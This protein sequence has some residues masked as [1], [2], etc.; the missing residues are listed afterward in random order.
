M[1]HIRWI[2]ILT[3]YSWPESKCMCDCIETLANVGNCVIFRHLTDT[4]TERERHKHQSR[5]QINIITYIQ[6]V[7]AVL[8]I[9]FPIS[10]C[11]ELVSHLLFLFFYSVVVFS[12][13][14]QIL[15]FSRLQKWKYT[16][17]KSCAS[18]EVT[19]IHTIWVN[20][21]DLGKLYVNSIDSSI[22][23][24]L[25]TIFTSS[26]SH[27]FDWIAMKI[28]LF[29]VYDSPTLS[30][31]TNKRNNAKC[32]VSC[33]NLFGWW[34]EFKATMLSIANDTKNSKCLNYCVPSSCYHPTSSNVVLF[35][36]FFLFF[37]WFNHC[38]T[39]YKITHSHTW[40][41]TIIYTYFLFI[42]LLLGMIWSLRRR[43]FFGCD[44]CNCKR[45]IAGID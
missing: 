17:S 8:Y 45:K 40:L 15:S 32:Q 16:N 28:T 31:E 6:K 33:T 1:R 23:I 41:H 21:I 2:C 26:I 36:L 37:I 5:S 29:I 43:T 42:F 19:T 9:I 44:I 39:L 35:S 22:F 18:N 4:D 12:I 27:T 20:S 14:V 38:S 11:L 25:R 24:L 34:F 7:S 30:T 13:R 3:Q 10:V